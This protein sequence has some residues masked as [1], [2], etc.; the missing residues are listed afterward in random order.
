[1]PLEISQYSTNEESYQVL[2]VQWEV[3]NDEPSDNFWELYKRVSKEEFCLR[4]LEKYTEADS[5]SLKLVDTDTSEVV[6]GTSWAI[7]TE[8]HDI[9]TEMISMIRT[10]PKMWPA[11]KKKTEVS[12]QW[13]EGSTF[14]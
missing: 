5:I 2:E 7:Y 13:G 11:M 3:Y 8:P 1:M 9:F 12:T 4:S 14:S 6:G 10:R